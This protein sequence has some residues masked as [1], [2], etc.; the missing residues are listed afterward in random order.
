MRNNIIILVIGLL[1][2]ITPN[3]CANDWGQWNELPTL[4][5]NAIVVRQITLPYQNVSKQNRMTQQTVITEFN[6]EKEVYSTAY[7]RAVNINEYRNFISVSTY[8]NIGQDAI[9]R[10]AA[11]AMHKIAI[12]PPPP[13]LPDVEEG[14]PTDRLPIGDGILP[15]LFMALTYAVIRLRRI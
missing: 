6:S 3:V 7:R 2:T 13:S 8:N 4:H 1:A 5:Q 10:S 9:G 11:P 12:A 14:N 15:L